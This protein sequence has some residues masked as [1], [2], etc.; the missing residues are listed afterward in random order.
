M[1]V[2]V[3]HCTWYSC[4][5]IQLLY[6]TYPVCFHGTLVC[7]Y[8]YCTLPTRFASMV[9]L[10]V[11]NYCTLPTQFASMVLLCVYTIIVLYLPGLLPWYSCV[12]IIIVLYLPSLLPWY[13]CVCIQLLYFTYPVCFH[14][15]LVCVYNY[16]TLP[17]WF[18]SM[19]LLCVYTIIVLYLPGLLP[20]YSCVCI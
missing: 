3:I 16:C 8:N 15:T 20:W 14:G 18:A 13:S 7:V 11:Y 1:V 10:C 2:H 5:C 4:V 6:F 12:C 17:T 9:L 19:V